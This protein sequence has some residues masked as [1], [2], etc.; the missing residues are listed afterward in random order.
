M[1][2]NEGDIILKI[3]CVVNIAVYYVCTR[4]FFV[5]SSSFLV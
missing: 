4:Y 5:L 2:K 1:I 3:I